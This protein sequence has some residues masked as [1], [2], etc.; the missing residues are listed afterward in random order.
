MSQLNPS[1]SRP[2]N[3]SEPS[4]GARAAASASTRAAPPVQARQQFDAAMQRAQDFD[5]DRPEPRRPSDA[6]TSTRKPRNGDTE[7]D[8]RDAL[9]ALGTLNPFANLQSGQLVPGAI[10]GAEGLLGNAAAQVPV[11]A[12]HTGLSAESL[13]SHAMGGARQYNLNLAGEN[14]AAMT[15]RMTQAGASHWQ[16]R[17]SADSTTRQQLGPHVDRLRDRLRERQ[18]QGQH[19]ADF[20]LEYDNSV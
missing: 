4:N 20:D 6:P 1:T 5:E 10:A 9:G 17:L 15:L 18:G 8:P 16:L 13:P 7:S 19:T 12:S 14:A 11:P 2:A 3:P